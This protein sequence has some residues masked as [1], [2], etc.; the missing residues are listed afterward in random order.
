MTT[1]KNRR[2]YRVDPMK[3]AHKQKRSLPKWIKKIPWMYV[4]VGG[5]C[6][7][8]IVGGVKLHSVAKTTHEAFIKYDS[9]GKLVSCYI[10][11]EEDNVDA[12]GCGQ[13][14]FYLADG[15]RIRNGDGYEKINLGGCGANDSEEE[16]LRKY[17]INPNDCMRL[18]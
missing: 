2:F 17:H 10:I 18:Y 7:M 3:M 11:L 6:L 8:F 4:I 14:E 12:T 9:D 13:F 1:D 15:T 5:I 16:M